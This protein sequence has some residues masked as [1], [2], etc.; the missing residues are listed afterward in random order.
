VKQHLHLR[1]VQVSPVFQPILW[2]T[3]A[4]RLLRRDP[5]TALHSAQDALLATTYPWVQESAVSI[6]FSSFVVV[7]QLRM[8]ILWYTGMLAMRLTWLWVA[9]LMRIEK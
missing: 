2:L 5:S 3:E 4:G 9:L 7:F 1:Q 6:I 8:V